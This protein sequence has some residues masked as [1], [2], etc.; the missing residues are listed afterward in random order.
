MDFKRKG[1]R[2]G[3]SLAEVTLALGIAS[4]A[5]LSVVGLLSLA[6][7]TSGTAGEDTSLTTMAGLITGDLH[8][9][10]FDQ[11]GRSTPRLPMADG[12]TIPATF[13]DSI[14][15]FTQEGVPLSAAATASSPD[16][17]FECVVKKSVDESFRS[18]GGVSNLVQMQLNFTWPVSTSP[19]PDKRPGKS[20]FHA[21]IARY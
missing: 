6:M 14:Y 7:N 4:I 3:F 1:T 13:V 5:L 8:A 19:D 17:H 11:L 16:A 12:E 2:F 18:V 20:T 15:Y 21:S 9:A 10:P